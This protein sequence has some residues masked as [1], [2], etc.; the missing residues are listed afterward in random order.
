M[1]TVKVRKEMT[2]VQT[3]LDAGKRKTI[4]M[5]AT[6]QQSRKKVTDL[7]VVSKVEESEVRVRRRG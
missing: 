3:E 6:L 7:K 4:S 5:N 1:S 2:G